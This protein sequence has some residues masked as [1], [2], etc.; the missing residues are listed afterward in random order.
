MIPVCAG[1]TVAEAGEAMTEATK[2][3]AS[4]ADRC[5]NVAVLADAATGWV[6]DGANRDK[7]GAEAA[8]LRRELRRAVNRVRKLANAAERNMCVAVYGPSQAGK[9]YLISVLGRPK[10]GE[11]MAAFDGAEP[12]KYLDKINPE[13]QGESTGLVTRFTV[14]K[15]P[16][17]EGHPV[18][19]RFLS[20]SD[21]AK[22]LT[23]AFAKDGDLSEPEP[24]PEEIDRLLAEAEAKAGTSVDPAFGVEAMWDVQEY[25]S[26]D[27]FGRFAYFAS[28]R[29]YWDRA[30]SVVP[31]LD[32]AGRAALLSVLWGRHA[33]LTDLF[34]TLAS[35]L[36]RLD[37]AREA[38]VP[39][40]ALVPREES[41][42]DVQT[43][44]ELDGE[45][46]FEP[47]PVR[48]VSGATATIPRG[49][50]TALVSE[51]IVPMAEKP[52]DFLSETDLLDFPGT[53]NRF[54]Y[55]LAN[56]L[57]AGEAP[58]AQLFLRGKVAYL[59]DRYVAEQEMT[60][61]LLCI[62][63]GNMEAKDLPGLMAR[64]V[65]ATHG[66]T[67]QERETALCILFF[68][69]TKF[70]TLLVESG[71]AG[72]DPRTRF[73]RRIQNSMLEPFGKLPDGWLNDWAGGKPFQNSFWLRNPEYEAAMIEYSENG[74][75][76]GIRDGMRD[77]VEALRKGAVQ[78]PL[79]CQHFAD[80]ESAWEAAMV[81]DDGG[82]SRVA[83]ALAEVC[84]PKVKLAQV[85]NQLQIQIQTIQRRLAPFHISSDV[86][87]RLA[88][89]R[90]AADQLVEALYACFDHNRWGELM[91]ALVVDSGRIADE[92]A[93]IPGDIHIVTSVEAERAASASASDGGSS[94]P[95][96]G[97]PRP[98]GGGVVPRRQ[99]A[100]PETAIAE[101]PALQMR[102]MTVEAF[103]SER[104]LAVWI[105]TLHDFL[106]R[107][108]RLARF[109]LTEGTASD[110]V[111][112]LVEAS[113]RLGLEARIRT[114]LERWNFS[115]RA[116]RRAG[117]A[118]TVAAESINAFVVGLGMN[119]L[120]ADRRPVVDLGDGES[121]HIFAEP[122]VRY[123]FRS[124]PDHP[125]LGAE[126]R[127]VD[128]TFALHRTFEDNARNVEGGAVN[129]EQNL[130]LGEILAELRAEGTPTAGG[131]L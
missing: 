101:H 100:P 120:A 55:E 125:R 36:K 124:L 34:R 38:F 22:I 122:P 64:W 31:R 65:A 44:K 33:P 51:M 116:E 6:G 103:Q 88:E 74:R 17:P 68:V 53:R 102:R 21:I 111:N 118:A 123:A 67:S 15:I 25:L 18:K 76:V 98:G 127:L 95:R 60:S 107:R 47:V 113:R 105:E 104:A 43:L 27:E 50:L 56:F 42:I 45:A 26:S 131:S 108:E 63:D 59:F 54:T 109:G 40:S 58:L 9:S 28:L 97:R 30:A 82:V 91:E 75:E 96:P 20:E 8:S 129:M 106:G 49:E 83:T 24:K 86:E 130:R 66:A 121:R 4:L 77:R 52:W 57:E 93:R 72:D 112:E 126:D 14:A 23:N 128:W 1:W 32:P 85:R 89:K 71:G 119:E 29:T 78:S 3:A 16:A 11:L 90:A 99:T 94:R 79:V 115:L 13:G 48:A 19:V 117:P 87:T 80:P 69:L 84:V 41:I 70:D 12:L 81:I 7:V 92:I 2:T 62:G 110:L 114:A 39:I 35:H 46:A 61:M 73:E 37:D 10:N 5:R